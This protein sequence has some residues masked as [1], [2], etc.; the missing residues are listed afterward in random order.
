MVK[1]LAALTLLAGA[2]P[3]LADDFFLPFGREMAGDTPLP[4]PIGVSVDF[5][6]MDQGYR[7]EQLAFT[8]P[9]VS[10]GSPDAI[11][12]DNRINHQDLKIDAWILPFLNVFGVWG[13]VHARTDVDLSGVQLPIN[14]GVL[15]VKYSGTVY[16]GGFT[17]AYCTENW[18]A[19]LTGTYTDTDLSGDFDSKVNSKSW[20]PRIGYITGPWAF[21]VGGMYLDVSEK[22]AGDITIPFLGNVPFAVTLS[23]EGDWNPNIGMHYN[24]NDFAEVSLEFGGGDRT[25]TLLNI[26]IRFP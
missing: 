12:V 4:R 19:T 6:T 8:L 9:G 18:F 26:G 5:F 11:E 7:I 22:H 15:P 25:T 16:G 2:A 10:L 24:F 17:L 3:A 23:Q 21:Y 1:M 13:H 14:L 20:Q